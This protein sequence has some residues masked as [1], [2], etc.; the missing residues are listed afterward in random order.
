MSFM[1]DNCSGLISL[2]VAGFDTSNV[3]DLSCLLQ[4]CTSLKSIDVSGF[5]TSKVTNMSS[6]FHGCASLTDLS[7][8]GF[9]T[10]NVT[11]MNYMFYGCEAI[12]RLDLTSFDTKNVTDMEDMFARC[13]SLTYLD[14]SSFNMSKVISLSDMLWSCSLETLKTPLLL[15]YNLSLPST[16]YDSEGNAYELSPK[17][18][19]D[20]I[21]LYSKSPVDPAVDIVSTEFVESASLN[22]QPRNIQYGELYAPVAGDKVIVT[23]SNGNTV[24]FEYTIY[25]STVSWVPTSTSPLAEDPNVNVSFADLNNEE[26]SSY[27]HVGDTVDGVVKF[28]GNIDGITFSGSAPFKSIIVESSYK[29]RLKDIIYVSHGDYAWVYGSY[30]LSDYAEPVTFPSTVSFSNGTTK[31]KFRIGDFRGLPKLTSIT[32]PENTIGI[33]DRCF[34]GTGLTEIT[35]PEACTSIGEYALGYDSNQNKVDGFK[36]RGYKGTAA[37]TY[38]NENGFTF[39]DIS[40]E[41]YPDEPDDPTPEPVSI[42]GASVTNIVTKT[43]TGR[44][45]T[46]SPVVKLKGVTLKNGVDYTLSYKNNINAS[47]A[48]YVTIT[49][50]GGYTGSITRKFTI[51]PLVPALNLKSVTKGSKSFTAKWPK[52][53]TAVQ[54]QFTGYQIQYSTSKTFASG[55]KVKSTTQRSAKKVVIRKLKKKKNYYV[56][57]R[58]YLKWNGQMVYSNWSAVKKVKTK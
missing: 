3:T 55:T 53:S 45:I 8:S 7:L 13:F 9:D 46:Q 14:L 23:L 41:P 37:E 35:I 48:A 30:K 4:N 28:E 49:G 12:T 25:T 43:R 11:D 42:V 36:I 18:L 20:S 58:R 54:K 57:I 17:N 1:F 51:Q 26:Y 47:T 39:I 5:E 22:G 40:G 33:D 44:A 31:S 16:M 29:V 15:K 52:A 19:T 34:I 2:D 27:T 6:M 24:T 38:A 10:S 32:L 50:K 56:R 21:V